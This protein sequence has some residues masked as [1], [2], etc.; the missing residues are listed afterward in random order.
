MCHRLFPKV[1]SECTNLYY[2][3]KSFNYIFEIIKSC[4]YI[5]EIIKLYLYHIHVLILFAQP[6]HVLKES[7]NYIYSRF[8]HKLEGDEGAAQKL[9]HIRSSVIFLGNR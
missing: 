3:K 8:Q 7:M 6:I 9:C 1:K 4:N 5:F 2:F